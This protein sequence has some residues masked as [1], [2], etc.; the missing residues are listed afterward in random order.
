MLLCPRTGWSPNR[1]VEAVGHQSERMGKQDSPDELQEGHGKRRLPGTEDQQC[2]FANNTGLDYLSQMAP[3][4]THFSSIENKGNY[5]KKGRTPMHSLSFSDI[6]EP[7]LPTYKG[8]IQHPSPNGKY[9]WIHVL[10]IHLG[11]TRSL[12]TVLSNIDL[13]MTWSSEFGPFSMAGHLYVNPSHKKKTILENMVPPF[14]HSTHLAIYPPFVS[15]PCLLFFLKA[16]SPT[17]LRWASQS[18]AASKWTH[19]VLQ[20]KFRRKSTIHLGL[21]E[22]FLLM[23]KKKKKRKGA[24]FKNLCPLLYYLPWTIRCSG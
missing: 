23:W 13:S 1:D 7:F 22:A 3:K 9:S 5:E 16:I 11:L 20:D 17:F 18:E 2:T 4:P 10:G 12:H 24:Y 15:C 21:T 6:K 19:G 14:P 8:I